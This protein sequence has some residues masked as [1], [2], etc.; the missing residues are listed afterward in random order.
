MNSYKIRVFKMVMKKKKVI[1]IYEK[2]Q[3]FMRE[4][5]FFKKNQLLYLEMLI[6]KISKASNN[7]ITEI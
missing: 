4:D 5:K 1:N 3:G 7:I 2:E 6:N